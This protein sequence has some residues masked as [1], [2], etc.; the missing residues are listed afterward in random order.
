M[1]FNPRPLLVTQPEQIPA[2]R[3]PPIRIN[4]VLSKQKD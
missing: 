2:H 3:F 4:I 1:R